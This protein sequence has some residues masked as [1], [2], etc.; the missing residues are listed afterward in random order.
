MLLENNQQEIKVPE[1]DYSLDQLFDSVN[2][3][4][5]R[6]ENFLDVTDIS[7]EVI[8][9]ENEFHL[10]SES[11]KFK[12][13]NVSCE[14][15][16]TKYET[17]LFNTTKRFRQALVR[18]NQR[19]IEKPD[20]EKASLLDPKVTP[21]RVANSFSELYEEYESSRVD[22]LSMMQNKMRDSRDLIQ[23][24]HKLAND[25]RNDFNALEDQMNDNEEFSA[26][27]VSELKIYQSSIYKKRLLT[28]FAV[29]VLILVLSVIFWTFSLP[30]ITTLSAITGLSF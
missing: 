3:I 23:Q 1:E 14:L 10:N 5:L 25:Q 29:F 28:I 17:W 7:D 19:H 6:L 9:L 13:A 15:N 18:C 22:R 12:M 8:T 26:K 16:R 24:L 30:I 4:I 2:R 27:T 21:P 11:I 20:I